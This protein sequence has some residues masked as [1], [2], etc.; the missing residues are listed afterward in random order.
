MDEITEV[1]FIR[2]GESESNRQGR[3]GGWFQ[4]PLSALGREQEDY[5]LG[6]ATHGYDPAKGPQPILCARGPS[7][8]SGARMEQ[9]R[10]I[11]IA[12]TV[13]AIMGQ[14]MPDAEGKILYALLQQKQ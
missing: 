7:F 4:A 1:Y 6:A 12:P 9:G 5:H 11:D 8:K 14:T 2:H 13:A 3:A 10:I